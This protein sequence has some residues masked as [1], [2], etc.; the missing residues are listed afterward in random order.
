MISYLK[1]KVINISGNNVL[2]ENNGIGWEIFLCDF[3]ISKISINSICEFYIHNSFSP[4]EGGKMYGFLSLSEKVI[5]NLLCDS[6]PDT[7]AKKAMDYLNKILKSV[8]DFK[9]A[10]K[11]QDIKTLKNL[12]GFTPKTAQKII[13]SLKD[14]VDRLETEEQ[15]K[16]SFTVFSKHYE[17]AINALVGLGYKL[18]DAR[19]AVNTV[20]EE[21]KDKN[22]N[23]EDLIKLS[24]KKLSGV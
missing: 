23:I 14:K 4:Y 11:T 16:Y 24:L 13:D 5:F 3:D 22:I 21:F 2:V 9:K 20:G 18:S 8:S 10:I 7:G 6:V 12:F 17:T 15:S 19:M 1:G